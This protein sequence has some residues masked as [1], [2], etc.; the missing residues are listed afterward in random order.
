MR[1]NSLIALAVFIAAALSQIGSAATGNFVCLTSP[2]GSLGSDP[3]SSCFFSTFPY[4]AIGLLVSFYVVTLAFLMGE[5]LN[6]QSLKGWYKNELWEA[7]KSVAL[8]IIIFAVIFIAGAMVP[9]I[10]PSGVSGTPISVCPPTAG[11][12]TNYNSCFAALY[13]FV[14]NYYLNPQLEVMNASYN[15]AIG[16]AMGISFVKSIKQMVYLPIPILSCS[17]DPACLPILD[18]GSIN[19]GADYSWFGSNFLDADPTKPPSFV[20]DALSIVIMPMLAVM[21]VLDFIVPTLIFVGLGIFLP[22]G[23]TLRAIPLLRGIGGT[24]IAVAIGVSLVLPIIMMVV[25]FPISTFIY[26]TL[27]SVGNALSSSGSLACFQPGIDTLL[28]PIITSLDPYQGIFDVMPGGPAQLPD[29][30]TIL[31]LTQNSAAFASGFYSGANSFFNGS[32]YN[33]LNSMFYYASAVVSQFILLIVDL[34]LTIVITG[35]VA[36]MLGGS[37]RLRIGSKI[38][39]T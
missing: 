4:V 18:W 1:G 32:I 24:L 38:K 11:G 37:L 12:S 10:W 23:L 39:L 17:P 16:L 3:I 22:L 21:A 34:I 2:S 36:R 35:N 19:F 20:K 27:N 8:V 29:G 30:T 13:N 9:T 25:N 14:E 15:N 7:V 5:V 28:C 26:S 31:P 6:L 33:V